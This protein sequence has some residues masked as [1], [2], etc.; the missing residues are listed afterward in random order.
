MEN[1]AAVPF[2]STSAGYRL[3]LCSSDSAG[4]ELMVKKTGSASRHTILAID[5]GGSRVKFMTDKERTKRAFA[6]GPDLSAKAMV[7]RSRR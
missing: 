5:V 2:V 6:S 3:R 1:K 4:R 7:R